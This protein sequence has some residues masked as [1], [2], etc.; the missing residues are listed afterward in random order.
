M[1]AKQILEEPHLFEQVEEEE[2][3]F[4]NIELQRRTTLNDNNR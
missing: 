4:D 1:W 2:T 3:L